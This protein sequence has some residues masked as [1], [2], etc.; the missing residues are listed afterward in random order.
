MYKL[1]GRQKKKKKISQAGMLLTVA[2]THSHRPRSK[3]R[4]EVFPFFFFPSPAS[5][6]PPHLP[7]GNVSVC[8]TLYVCYTINA[9][10]SV[11]V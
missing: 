1:W 10:Q 8:M 9:Q 2:A 3:V 5:F 11:S 4:M 6:F 7:E